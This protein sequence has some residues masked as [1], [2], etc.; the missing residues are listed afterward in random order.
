MTKEHSIDSNASILIKHF[1]HFAQKYESTC[2]ANA[3][4]REHSARSDASAQ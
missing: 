4:M 3:D 1:K 2:V